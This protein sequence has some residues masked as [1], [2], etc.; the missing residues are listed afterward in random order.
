M[1][2]H[3]FYKG[4]GDYYFDLATKKGQLGILPLVKKSYFFA[5]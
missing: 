1:F 3:D 4:I 2:A 5:A